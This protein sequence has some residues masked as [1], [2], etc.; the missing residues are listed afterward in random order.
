MAE[1]GEFLN[2]MGGDLELGD[3]RRAFEGAVNAAGASF[4][5]QPGGGNYNGYDAI[6]DLMIRRN[7]AALL[8][9]CYPT[10]WAMARRTGGIPIVFAA[11][12]NEDRKATGYDFAD[13]VTGYV[14]FETQDLCRWWPSLLLQIKP[15][16]NEI[17]VIGDIDTGNRLAQAQYGEIRAALPGTFN[18]PQIDV[19]LNPGQLRQAIDAFRMRNPQG[20]LIVTVYSWTSI[21]RQTILSAAAA[22]NLPAIYPSDTFV[23]QRRDKGLITYGPNV[24][25]L[26]QRAG[27]YVDQILQ[28]NIPA[29]QIRA[30]LPVVVN[31]VFDIYISRGTFAALGLGRPPA[32]LN[33]NGQRIQPNLV[34]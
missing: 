6:A 16:L 8:A 2:L 34:S 1:V 21:Q 14:S 23:N 30:T 7:P 24:L 28:Q 9:S 4:F 31:R 32:T 15:T 13:N 10:M 11:L 17:A 20:G 12:C 27:G 18:L 29:N 33:V 19:T 22:N 25:N 3:R 5:P 26:Y